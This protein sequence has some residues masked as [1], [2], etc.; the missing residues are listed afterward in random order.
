MSNTVD[1]NDEVPVLPEL[2]NKDFTEKANQQN[3]PLEL[4][5]QT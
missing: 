5:K 3:R 1:H 4:M 2:E